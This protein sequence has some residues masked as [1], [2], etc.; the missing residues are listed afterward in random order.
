MCGVVA[1]RARLA[2]ILE[3]GTYR[4]RR[5]DGQWRWIL[6]RG[7]AGFDPEG[8]PLRKLGTH[9]DVTA[10]RRLQGLMRGSEARL[11]EAQ[12]VAH[13]RSWSLRGAARGVARVCAA[14]P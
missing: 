4:V 7:K 3:P 6:V 5:G 12:A 9:T 2:E 10:S 11:L 13:I 1:G 14:R 8:R